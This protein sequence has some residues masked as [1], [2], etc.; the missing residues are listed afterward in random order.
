MLDLILN[1]TLATAIHHQIRVELVHTEAPASLPLPDTD[2]VSLVVNVMDNAVKAARAAEESQRFIQLDLRV[3]GNFFFFR[4]TNSMVPGTAAPKRSSSAV[5]RHGHGLKIIQRIL[6]E[7]GGFY[8]IQ[9]GEDRF[10]ITLT[11]PLS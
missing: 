10:Q 6:S 8:R 5:S 7:A 2:L 9:T 11:L 3:Q 4:C 1:G